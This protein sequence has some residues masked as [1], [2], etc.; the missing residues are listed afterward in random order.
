APTVVLSGAGDP[1]G[2]LSPLGLLSRVVRRAARAVDGETLESRRAALGALASG[3]GGPP[4]PRL[5]C[6]LGELAGVPFDPAT[7]A[8][9]AAAR[10]DRSLMGD[11]IRRAWE[12]FLSR[13]SARGPVALV[14]DDLHWGDLPSVKL[15]DG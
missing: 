9:L 2:A 12:E 8:H 3:L 6:F 5:A 15:V 7:D 4:D 11:Q 13:L 10:V 14:L 1:M